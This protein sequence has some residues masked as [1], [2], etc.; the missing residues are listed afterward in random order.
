MV[1]N[2]HSSSLKYLCIFILQEAASN[3][4]NQAGVMS[5]LG[6]LVTTFVPAPLSKSLNSAAAPEP[7]SG[8][9]LKTAAVLSCCRARMCATVP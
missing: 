4:S 8:Q 1:E 9:Q 3:E 2:V 7:L 5:G 6:G